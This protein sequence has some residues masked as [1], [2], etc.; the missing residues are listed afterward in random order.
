[1]TENI[2]Y[3]ACGHTASGYVN[4][5]E[6]NL[7][8]ID[9]VIV[10]QH[11]AKQL[12]SDILFSIK[13]RESKQ[14]SYEILCSPYL[15]DKIEGLILRDQSLAVLS[16]D[17]IQKDNQQHKLIDLTDWFPMVL[18]DQTKEK[19]AYLQMEA[20][21]KFS[22]ALAIHDDLERVFINE[23]D[24]EKA[25]KVASDL[26]RKMF[27]DVPKQERKAHVYERLFGTNTMDGAIN[28]V[29][30]LIS[31]IKHL[32]YVKG[33]AGTGKSVLL[34]KVVEASKKYGY[35]V[36]LYR[37]SF[38]PHSIDMVLIRDLDYCLFDSTDPHAFFPTRPT[39]Q[40]IDLYDLTVTPGTDEKYKAEISNI[41]YAYKAE[42]QAGLAYLQ[43]LKA[44]PP[45]REL[46]NRLN[47]SYPMIIADI[48][49]KIMNDE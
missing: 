40:V 2:S 28:E 4:F 39:D 12:I 20:Y 19:V 30:K 24:F 8:G 7:V 22:K 1:M 43:Q 38:D 5:I 32:V 36:E 26:L 11:P 3:Y 34:K 31:P 10:L 16:Q 13:S 35:D 49:Q 15:A 18:T 29:E 46:S 6:S 45:F 17:L 21:R 27:T 33:R 14:E 48:S 42:M 23:M 44:L 25:D 47:E 37:C 9:K 41:T